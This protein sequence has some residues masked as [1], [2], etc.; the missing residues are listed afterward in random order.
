MLRWPIG[1]VSSR[2]ARGR[3]LLR[4][5]L[6]RRGVLVPS[7]VVSSIWLAGTSAAVSLPLLESTI[8]ASLGSSAA[9]AVPALVLSL[10]HGVLRTMWIKKLVSNAA[11]V[12]LIG[13]MSGG[14]GVWAHW[15]SAASGES[16]ARGRDGQALV[17]ATVGSPAPDGGSASQVAALS[18]QPEPPAQ[19]VHGLPADCPLSIAATAIHRMI[20][21]VHGAP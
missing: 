2:L 7:A 17:A 13:V 15:P 18:Q 5:R 4:S 1:T 20:D 14:L 8:S 21:H 19:S 9:H 16:A 11:A 3:R 6:E 12:L 10:T